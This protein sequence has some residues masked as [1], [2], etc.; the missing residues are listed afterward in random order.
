MTTTELKRALESSGIFSRN[1]FSRD[2]YI[3]ELL[4]F[5]RFASQLILNDETA[6][7]DE[8]IAAVSGAARRNGAT[9]KPA[10]VA[11]IRSLKN[12][13]KEIAIHMSGKYAEDEIA[14]SLTFVD[15][16]FFQ[17]F[18]NIYVADQKTETEIDNVILT[19]NGIIVV[20]VKSAKHD[21]TISEDG[22]LLYANSESY[23]NESI[24]EKMSTKR[25]LLKI[26]IENKLRERGLDIPVYIESYLVFV[27]PKHLKV[28][29]TDNFHKEHWCRRGKLQHIVK[30]FIGDVTYTSEEYVQLAEIIGSL[31]CNVKRFPTEL[32]LPAI[33]NNFVALYA[34]TAEQPVVGKVEP[35]KA[36]MPQIEDTSA[37]GN[38]E[39]T[40]V[41][42]AR[43][44]VKMEC[45]A[46]D[47]L[48]TVDWGN[49]VASLTLAVIPIVVA[50]AVD[51]KN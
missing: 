22:R 17:D 12:I 28:T 25:R 16:P 5:Q 23:H 50:A 45:H 49:V 31:D 4:K 6:R 13:E 32:D 1:G 47:W 37:T 20:E 15:R 3:E 30:D 21:I 41:L 29:I 27:T 40:R 38:D 43:E 24:G 33:R 11:G 2:E 44:T 9:G 48:K 10:F 14:H 42:P 19:N 51:K 36:L 8:V 39:S 34:L 7:L 26:N 35:L 18:R 46:W